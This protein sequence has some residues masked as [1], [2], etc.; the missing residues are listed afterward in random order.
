MWGLTYFSEVGEYFW[1]TGCTFL[2]KISLID[3]EKELSMSQNN[4]G[5]SRRVLVRFRIAGGRERSVHQLFHSKYFSHNGSLVDGLLTIA[6]Q[7]YSQLRQL[8]LLLK[9]DL[10]TI[11]EDPEELR[12]LAFCNK[13]KETRLRNLRRT[14]RSFRTGEFSLQCKDVSCP[15]YSTDGT[16]CPHKLDIA[17]A[18]EALPEVVNCAKRRADDGSDALIIPRDQSRMRR[19]LLDLLVGRKDI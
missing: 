2:S 5:F 7:A 18:R 1:K 19:R 8:R 17:E 10:T 6:Q 3:T 14:I 16:N 12:G 11:T 4:S 9:I 13:V 15:R